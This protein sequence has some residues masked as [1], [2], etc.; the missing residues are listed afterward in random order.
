[1]MNL[2]E[3]LRELIAEEHHES[4]GYDPTWAD[5]RRISQAA[6]KL[7]LAEASALCIRNSESLT[8]GRRVV[9]R[10]LSEEI[11]ELAKKLLP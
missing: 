5:V 4:R 8:D 11:D 7:A 10:F 3:K 2:K 9:A 1:M 6:V